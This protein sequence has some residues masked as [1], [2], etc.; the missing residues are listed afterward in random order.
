[1]LKSITVGAKNFHIFSFN[2]YLLDRKEEILNLF[3]SYML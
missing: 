3:G 2:D 1:M